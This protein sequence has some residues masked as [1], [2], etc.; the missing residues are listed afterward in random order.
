MVPDKPLRIFS[1][2]ITLNGKLLSIP[3]FQ[4]TAYHRIFYANMLFL[5]CTLCP[6][7]TVVALHE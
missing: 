3:F 7:I 2:K 4:L 5:R 6:F 1:C